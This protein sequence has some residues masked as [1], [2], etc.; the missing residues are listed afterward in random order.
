[1]LRSV[2]PGVVTALLLPLVGAAPARA[3]DGDKNV[4]EIVAK[5]IKAKGG[6]A[7]LEKYKASTSKFSGTVSIMGME[8]KMS[9]T[10]KDMVP[11]K[12]RLDA[13]MSVGGQDVSFTQILNGKKGWQGLNGGVDEMDKDSLAEAIEQTYASSLIDLRGLNAPGVKLTALGESKVDGKPAVGIR[14]SSEGHRDVSLFFS[15]DNGLLLKSETKGKDPM[16]G[17]EFNT[18]TYYSDYKEA[19][20]LK[21]AFKVKV[22]RDGNPFMTMQMSAVTLAEKLDDKEFS[23][24]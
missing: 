4:K 14:A 20:G 2:F 24:P 1:M 21:E 6:A 3:S 16:A 8:I 11:G 9:G 15:K 17:T 22:L 10:S 5:A 7:N 23:K 18:E 12:T 13:S 19:G